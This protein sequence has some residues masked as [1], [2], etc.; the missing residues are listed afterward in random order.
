MT[1][2][3]D[4]FDVNAEPVKF[5]GCFRPDSKE[6]TVPDLD[7][8]E[9]EISTVR[10]SVLNEPAF[11]GKHQQPELR[12]WLEEKREQCSLSGNLSITLAAA[13]VA[14]PFAVLGA[15]M[16]G[17]QTIFGMLF[18]VVFGPVIEELLKQSGMVYLLEKKPY[19]IFSVFQ[20]V[21]A[22]IIS[23]VFFAS[24]ENLLYIHI[25]SKTQSFTDFHG[26][27]CYRWT[28]CIALH[29]ICSVIA[30]LGLV[31]VWKK[32]LTDGRAADLSMAFG[33]FLAAIVIHGLY[34][35]SV[36]VINPQF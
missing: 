30:S 28:Y 14:G 12:Q 8:T 20:F 13:L 32:Q 5:D 26:F 19:R 36:A 17:R 9:D 6:I 4:Y 27:C 25:Y 35:F 18:L 10:D 2:N 1:P 7:G 11:T 16:T 3:E 21:F 23:A 24:I 33:Y 22:A 31:R 34:N 29:V 15:F